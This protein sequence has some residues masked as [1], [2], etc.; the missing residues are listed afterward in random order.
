M[1]ASICNWRMKEKDTWIFP[2]LPVLNELFS[3]NITDNY[4][5]NE[6]PHHCRVA[7]YTPSMSINAHGSH[8][9]PCI[10]T[11][12]QGSALLQRNWVRLCSLQSAIRRQTGTAG[13]ETHDCL[14]PR[15]ELCVGNLP[16]AEAPLQNLHTGALKEFHLIITFEF[17]VYR[18]N[19][20]VN[21]LFST[22]LNTRVRVT[23]KACRLICCAASNWC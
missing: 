18:Q 6:V 10:H 14:G 9:T 13:P 7:T 23:H 16:M 21:W 2:S 3:Q 1:S 20:M 22:I 11:Y 17:F 8:S 4:K 19:V 5:P 12:I 15:V